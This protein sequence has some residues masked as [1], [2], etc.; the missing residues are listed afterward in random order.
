MADIA[1]G[2][3]PTTIETKKKEAQLGYWERRWLACQWKVEL[4]RAG[5]IVRS[6][7]SEQKSHAIC[8]RHCLQKRTSQHTT[9]IHSAGT[10]KK[11]KYTWNYL[12]LVAYG[13]LSISYMICTR[14]YN[15][16]HVFSL[17]CHR[18]LAIYCARITL[19]VT[20]HTYSTVFLATQASLVRQCYCMHGDHVRLVCHCSTWCSC[21]HWRR[22]LH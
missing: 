5:H 19:H 14:I 3:Y 15:L 2:T 18:Y 21:T 4:R 9:N 11:C 17:F 22:H 16:H 20:T 7:S 13:L 6:T 8:A 12:S 1:A 10:Y